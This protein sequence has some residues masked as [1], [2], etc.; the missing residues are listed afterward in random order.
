MKGCT[1]AFHSKT[2]E[3]IEQWAEEALQKYWDYGAEE[4]AWRTLRYQQ[5][6]SLCGVVVLAVYLVYWKFIR[7]YRLVPRRISLQW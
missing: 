2:G 5:C 6:A 3:E 7:R 4:K 1:E